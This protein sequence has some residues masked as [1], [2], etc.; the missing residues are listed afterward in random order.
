MNE[1]VGGKGSAYKYFSDEGVDLGQRTREAANYY[2]QVLRPAGEVP[3]V[4][5]YACTKEL[6]GRGV[7]YVGLN[8]DADFDRMSNPEK[9]GTILTSVQFLMRTPYFDLPSLRVITPTQRFG[10]SFVYRGTFHL[11]G[12][13]AGEVYFYGIEKL[14]A[15]KPDMIAAEKAFQR[16]VELDPSI[17]F[18]HI[19]LANLLLK[20][21]ASERALG[22]Y[23][24]AL[25]YAPT[26]PRFGSRSKCRS[27]F[28]A[29]CQQS[30]IPILR[31]PGLE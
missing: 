31:N 13:A 7:D 19:E 10:K 5:C 25:L 12:L 11:P 6:K 2:Y 8:P 18:V 15:E 14:Y 1:L 21:G 3:Y 28:S 29:E 24:Q 9:R 16:S 22:E 27:A 17:F 4:L 30:E 23:S 20:R 26:D